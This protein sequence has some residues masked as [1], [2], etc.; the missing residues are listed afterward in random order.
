MAIRGRHGRA[1]L[2]PLKVT[3]MRRLRDSGVSYRVLG[4][5]FGVSCV[6]ARFAVIGKNWAHVR[7]EG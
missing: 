6:N 2:T 1:K 4:R 7:D 5:M 3:E